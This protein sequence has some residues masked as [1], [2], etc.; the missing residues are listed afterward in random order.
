MFSFMSKYIPYFGS[1]WS[2]ASFKISEY[3]MKTVFGADP[4][5]II[6]I[7]LGKKS[8]YNYYIEGNYYMVKFDAEKGGNA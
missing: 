3:N 7:T 5:T 2:F 8:W 1:E 6:I 4:D